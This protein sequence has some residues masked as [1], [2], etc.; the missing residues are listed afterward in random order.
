[1]VAAA[2]WTAPG[3]TAGGARGGREGRAETR[4]RKEEGEMELHAAD[5]RKLT[6][7]LPAAQWRRPWKDQ[8]G[9]CALLPCWRC[10]T[11]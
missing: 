11:L 8:E 4:G 3:A 5:H 9:A 10:A 1:M 2:R 6:G 7:G